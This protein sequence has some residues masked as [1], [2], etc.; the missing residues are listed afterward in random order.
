MGAFADQDTTY[1]SIT[2]SGHST[3]HYITY[4][5]FLNKYSTTIY[6]STIIMCDWI[7]QKSSNYQALGNATQ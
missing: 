2:Q 1:C 7:W 6:R 5:H 3:M 4:V